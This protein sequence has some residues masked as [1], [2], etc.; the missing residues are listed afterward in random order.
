MKKN[1]TTYRKWRLF[2]DMIEMSVPTDF[3]EYNFPNDS[4]QYEM[5]EE[6]ALW[7]NG[8]GDAAAIFRIEENSREI[9]DIIQIIK[10][11]LV[12]EKSTLKNIGFYSRTSNNIAQVMSEDELYCGEEGIYIISC[13]SKYEDLCYMVYQLGIPDRKTVIKER[14]L[15]MLD[16]IHFNKEI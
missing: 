16:S 6:N 4:V 8:Q 1:Y 11:Q 15:Y 14:M 5:P 10:G 3:N 12:T 9:Q 7:T 2:N 13:V